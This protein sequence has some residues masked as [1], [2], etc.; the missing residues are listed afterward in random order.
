[1]GQMAQAT[2]DVNHPPAHSKVVWHL[3]NTISKKETLTMLNNDNDA[4]CLAQLKAFC[5]NVA[6]TLCEG[7]GERLN[8]D[9]EPFTA[10]DWIS[11]ETYK[12]QWLT[13]ITCTEFLGARLM[14]GGGGPSYWL[15]SYQ[16]TVTGYW[17]SLKYETKYY[18]TVGLN[19]ALESLFEYH[20][21]SR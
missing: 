12:V 16:E 8:D 5:D 2:D 20:N 1:M 13:D 21:N 18:D 11:K 10:S 6:E 7:W 4:K 9:G 14:L 19:D 3:I 15:D 17:G